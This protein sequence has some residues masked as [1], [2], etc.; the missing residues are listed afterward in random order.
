M[1]QTDIGSIILIN[2]VNSVNVACRW[3]SDEDYEVSSTNM[4]L[5]ILTLI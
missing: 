1:S 2:V 4:T 3:I 5:T